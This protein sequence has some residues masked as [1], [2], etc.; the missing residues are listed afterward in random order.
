[1]LEATHH[2]I[3]DRLDDGA[4]S[5]LNDLVQDVEVLANEKIGVHVANAFIQRSR[6]F[7]IS[8]QIGDVGDC[9]A[10][11]LVH[12]LCLVK[13]AEARGQQQP[14][15][16]KKWFILDQMGLERGRVLEEPEAPA[17]SRAILNLNGVLA[18]TEIGRLSEREASVAQHH[19]SRPSR[20][21]RNYEPTG[22]EPDLRPLGFGRF[23]VREE[24][25]KQ[26][27]AEVEHLETPGCHVKFKA[28]LPI[29]LDIGKSPRQCGD[30]LLVRH[31]VRSLE[32]LREVITQVVV[33]DGQHLRMTKYDV[34]HGNRDG[35]G[36]L[37]VVVE[38]HIVE[39]VA[40]LALETWMNL[41]ELSKTPCDLRAICAD[42]QP[43][44]FEEAH[45]CGVHEQ[46]DSFDLTEAVSCRV[47]DG[48][49]AK[50]IIVAGRPD[51]MFEAREDVRRPARHR[52]EL[53][54]TLPEEVL[55]DERRLFH[56]SMLPRS[57]SEMLHRKT[58]P[59]GLGAALNC[60][61]RWTPF[62]IEVVG[63]TTHAHRLTS[64]PAIP[65]CYASEDH[66]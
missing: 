58:S 24:D 10:L 26:L 15:A 23:P 4:G 5:L 57:L 35:K 42:E 34:P 41:V 31:S 16:G 47:L 1:M 38:R 36:D 48:I 43:L 33:L 11:P 66:S 50:Q 2:F 22:L 9:Q 63:A 60:R 30:Q 52:P 3:A 6:I 55:V 46:L 54:D 32:V 27:V 62:L 25:Q 40:E 7:Q 65:R 21:I 56:L 44:H 51:E 45:L 18:W 19:F 37:D 14:P 17:I 61:L 20:P 49:D 28:P 59:T 13:F 39:R 64:S 8:E 12:Q 53:S 29:S